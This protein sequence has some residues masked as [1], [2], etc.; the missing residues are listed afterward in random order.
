[1][2]RQQRPSVQLAA[3]LGVSPAAVSRWPFGKDVPSISS[4]RKLAKYSG[5][6]LENVPSIAGHPPR[7]TGAAASEWPE[8]REYAQ[9]RYPDGLDEDLI[10]V[11]EDLIE[12]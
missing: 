2:R 7:V 10:T 3:N 5:V 12:L 6:P 8:F 1:M 9:Q 11:M 4:R